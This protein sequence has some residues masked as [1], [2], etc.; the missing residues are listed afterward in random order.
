MGVKLK[1]SLWSHLSGVLGSNNSSLTTLVTR[2]LNQLSLKGPAIS[3]GKWEKAEVYMV[4]GL[5]RDILSKKMPRDFDFATNAAPSVI[6]EL[7]KT[8]KTHFGD[9]KVISIRN[10]FQEINS[11][12]EVITTLD[13]KALYEKFKEVDSIPLTTFRPMVSAKLYNTKNKTW[14]SWEIASYQIYQPPT[15]NELGEYT[16]NTLM[17]KSLEEHLKNADYTI[18]SLAIDKEGNIVDYFDGLKDLENKVLRTINDAEDMF[19]NQPR[20]ILRGIKILSQNEFKLDKKTENALKNSVFE[21]LMPVRP[22]IKKQLIKEILANP[23]GIKLLNKYNITETIFSE[24]GSIASKDILKRITLGFNNFHKYYRPPKFGELDI[25]EGAIYTILL[26]FI[27]EGYGENEIED[28]YIKQSMNWGLNPELYKSITYYNYFRPSESLRKQKCTFFKAI[29][30]YLDSKIPTD[31]YLVKDELDLFMKDMTMNPKD[32][33]NYFNASIIPIALDKG[34]KLDKIFS[35]NRFLFNLYGPKYQKLIKYKNKAIKHI[36]SYYGISEEESENIC[37]ELIANVMISKSA[38]ASWEYIL[39]N[40]LTKY[41]LSFAGNIKEIA[42]KLENKKDYTYSMEKIV[43]DYVLDERVKSNTSLMNDAKFMRDYREYITWYEDYKDEIDEWEDKQ[44]SNLEFFRK[45]INL[46][47]AS[48]ILNYSPTKKKDKIKNWVNNWF[49][50]P[51]DSMIL[52]DYSFISKSRDIKMQREM[53]SKL[54]DEDELKIYKEIKYEYNRFMTY[55]HMIWNDNLTDAMQRTMNEIRDKV[56]KLFKDEKSYS[57]F[58]P[59]NIIVDDSSTPISELKENENNGKDLEYC[60]SCKGKDFMIFKN[61]KGEK[62]IKC[63]SSNCYV[64]IN[65]SKQLTYYKDTF[66]PQQIDWFIFYENTYLHKPVVSNLYERLQLSLTAEQRKTL[67]ACKTDY[68]NQMFQVHKN[69]NKKQ[70]SVEEI[71]NQNVNSNFLAKYRRILL[72]ENIRLLRKQLIKRDV[73]DESSLDL[74]IKKSSED[75]IYEHELIYDWILFNSESSYKLTKIDFVRSIF[76]STIRYLDRTKDFFPLQREYFDEIEKKDN[77][78]DIYGKFYR[79]ISNNY[80]LQLANILNQN[81]KDTSNE[82]STSKY[83]KTNRDV[84]K[85]L[86]NDMWFDEMHLENIIPIYYA[87]RKWFDLEY[88]LEGKDG[89]LVL[90]ELST[91]I[92]S[93]LEIHQPESWGEVAKIYNDLPIEKMEFGLLTANLSKYIYDVCIKPYK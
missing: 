45:I 61:E 19:K 68:N 5:A 72:D 75:Q 69:F 47:T 24:Y 28:D 67:R 36:T 50:Y 12:G 77:W 46:I 23:S 71:D 22:A 15:I 34:I 44:V 2:F 38:P 53:I 54:M 91:I 70:E 13:E 82:L 8:Y 89:L 31:L 60:P 10:Y 85:F 32:L 56:I 33:L 59:N 21:E 76:N 48:W 49:S 6:V 14:W 42:G 93:I 86:N 52:S 73:M 4:G 1:S 81:N 55:G 37:N 83:W 65:P 40:M 25:S 9:T 39:T 18:N 88:K 78:D 35:K 58:Y 26:Y 16:S 84:L 57:S 27:S 43:S 11:K 74:S 7:L 64:E 92:Y 41:K 3:K 80:Y 79:D 66:D 87:K 17:V 51:L 20:T 90:N 63:I 30:N 62:I 29:V